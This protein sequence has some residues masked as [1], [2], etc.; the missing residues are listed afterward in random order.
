M[1]RAGRDVTWSPTAASLP[2]VLEAAALLADEGIEAEVIDLRVLR[3]LDGD[4]IVG[5]VRRTHRLLVV[6]EGWRSGSLAA[7]IMARV[8]EQAFYEL[9]APP[10]RVCSAEVP[11]PYPKHLEEAALPHAGRHRRGGAARCSAA[12]MIEFRLPSLG[13]DMDEGT[14][15]EWRVAPGR[16]R[17]EGRHRRGRR[18]TKAAIDVECWH[19]GTVEALLVE[20][21]R[22]DPGR[23]GDGGAARG[24]RDLEQVRAQVDA[25]RAAP[26]PAAAPVVAAASRGG[27]A[28]AAAAAGVAPSRRP[29][30]GGPPNCM[31]RSTR[32]WARAPR[33]R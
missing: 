8:I 19:D 21:G 22:R 6:D 29:R 5:S 12:R 3:P 7:E 20:T 10:A 33:A 32:S 4:T 9:D 17:E 24:G 31:S 11:M 18:H 16:P 23:H 28:P 14:L 26:A 13:A 27:A 15:L 25:L 1:R 2:R 30:A